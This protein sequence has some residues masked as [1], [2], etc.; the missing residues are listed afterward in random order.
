MH[1]S[2]RYL[3]SPFTFTCVKP[4]I[5]SF[6]IRIGLYSLCKL[7]FFPQFSLCETEVCLPFIYSFII[8]HK[9]LYLA[10]ARLVSHHIQSSLCETEPLLA[11]CF[12]R[13]GRWI[14]GACRL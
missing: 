14:R 7:S 1:Y 5:H 9:T 10:I 2:L 11:A 3:F 8:T 13:I 4:R 6:C 12:N